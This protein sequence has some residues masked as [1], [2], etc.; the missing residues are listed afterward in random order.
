M[1]DF[2]DND[3]RL[4]EEMGI[5]REKVYKQIETF[6]EGIPYTRL[7][8]AAVVGDGILR[9]SEAETENI[10]SKFENKTA[11]LAT[12]KFVPASG[13][14]SRMFKALFNFLEAFNPGK[15]SLEEYLNRDGR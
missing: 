3:L 9:F 11:S 1:I 7:E 15:E 10:V 14:A 6:V 5:S 12:L 2:L 13:A 8:R 4:L